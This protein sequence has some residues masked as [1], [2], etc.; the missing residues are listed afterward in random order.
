MQRRIIL[1]AV[2]GS[3]AYGLNHA[4][5]DTDTMGIFIA[6]TVK[7][8]GLNWGKN[9]M[10]W[11]NAGPTGDDSTLHEVGK[12][13][14]LTLKSNPT[15]LELFFME[16][17]TVLDSIGEQVLSVKD[18]VLYETGVRSAYYGYAVAQYNR[19]CNEYPNHKEKMARHC[20]RIS[21]QGAE[22]LK[23]GSTTLKVADPQEYFDL[24]KL[25]F[26]DMTKKLVHAI[27]EIDT[28]DSILPEKPDTDK[29]AAVLE[30]IR[31]QN[32]G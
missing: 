14:R 28:V 11:S 20:L 2:T 6:P 22:L 29:V 30:D 32:I 15:L 25:S 31:R 18:A 12:F 9:D 5:S 1:E 7:V 4:Q 10:S 16:E 8:A 21:R 13:L 24:S 17:Y 26:D 19:I 27:A 23:T 3:K